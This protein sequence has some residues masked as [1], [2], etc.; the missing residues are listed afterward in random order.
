[1]PITDTA[2]E[3]N[4][5][6]KIINKKK[7]GIRNHIQNSIKIMYFNN[8]FNGKYWATAGL[9]LSGLPGGPNCRGSTVMSFKM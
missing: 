1:M 3:H 9:K 2:Q 7:R 6:T 5:N 8:N 4:K